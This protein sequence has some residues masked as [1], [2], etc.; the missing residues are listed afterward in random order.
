MKTRTE[1]LSR[2]QKISERIKNAMATVQ[3]NLNESALPVAVR[4]HGDNQAVSLANCGLKKGME[5]LRVLSHAQVLVKVAI[6]EANSKAG[7]NQ[8][9]AERSALN[10]AKGIADTLIADA[11]SSMRNGAQKE[12]LVP[13]L[14]RLIDAGDSGAVKIT[15]IGP[16][17]LSAIE[18]MSRVMAVRLNAISDEINS[19]NA[20][21]KVT[22]KLSSEAEA[23]I[24]AA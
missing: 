9:L 17:D 7:I 23:L 18:S 16:A 22:L 20:T 1:N 24:E 8:L 15:P 4:V 11:K 13:L 5:H 14:Q 19:I 3:Y 12:N 2:A 6:A 10:H 21:T